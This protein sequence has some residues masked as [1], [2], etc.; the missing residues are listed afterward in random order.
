MSEVARH[1]SEVVLVGVD[2]S[3][4]SRAALRWAVARAEVTGD[5]LHLVHVVDDE[6]MRARSGV[7]AQLDMEASRLLEQEAAYVRAMAPSVPTGVEVRYGR[8]V[9]ELVKASEQ[10]SLSVM[11]THKTGFISGRVFG[12]RSVAF[13]AAA[14]SPVA[15]I[16]QPALTVRHGQRS[17]AERQG[18]VVGVDNTPTGLAAVRLAAVEAERSG[19][20]LTLLRA[21]DVPREVRGSA[22]LR[23]EA[24]A[25]AESL[26][27][28]MVAEAVDAVGRENAALAVTTRIV[29]GV[30]AE[31][32]VDASE[33]AGL[34][35]IGGADSTTWGTGS[36]GQTVHDVLI[37]VAAP[38]IVSRTRRH[39]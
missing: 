1:V 34:L 10:A 3:T 39:R 26:A 4:P 14:R 13:G 25:T 32:L 30:T 11:G 31:V 5:A 6:W 8:V 36:M 9:Q 24:V 19:V 28:R 29:Q 33:T 37:N 22:E 23:N 12:S 21:F 2:S 18:V 27:S 15:I 16:P 35:V 7:S 17:P 38:T 20:P